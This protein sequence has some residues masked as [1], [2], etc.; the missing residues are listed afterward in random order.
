MIAT[1]IL[2]LAWGIAGWLVF[3]SLMAVLTRIAD[4]LD[5][6]ADDLRNRHL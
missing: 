4:T 6:I 2:G 5:F 1:Y 3:R